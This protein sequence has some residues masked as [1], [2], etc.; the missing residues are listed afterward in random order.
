MKTNHQRNF[1]ECY[2]DTRAKLIRTRT[3]LAIDCKI[4]NHT[5]SPKHP[6]Y[7]FSNGRRGK[8][9]ARKGM[10]KYAHSR[11]RFHDN[12]ATKKIGLL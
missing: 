6:G 12:A 5:V 10:K 9:K 1:K 2:N 7:E 8:S 3:T 4:A 11:L